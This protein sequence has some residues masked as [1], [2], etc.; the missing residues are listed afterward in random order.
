[1]SRSERSLASLE[2]LV[3]GTGRVDL[4]GYGI[5]RTPSCQPDPACSVCNADGIPLGFDD[6]SREY[7]C[8]T[9]TPREGETCE[10]YMDRCREIRR[11][12]P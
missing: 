1:M 12:R 4:P 9:C 2:A 5:E 10:E 11:T 3:N 8:E 7:L 6:L